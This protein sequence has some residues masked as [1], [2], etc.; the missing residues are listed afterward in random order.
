MEIEG[1]DRARQVIAVADLVL[2]WKIDR[3]RARRHEII[4]INA[5]RSN[6]SDLPHT[7]DDPSA[8]A[9]SATDRRR[10]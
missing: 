9:V 5:L 3:G 6:K 10:R 8:V 1:G 2:Q 4:I 7:W